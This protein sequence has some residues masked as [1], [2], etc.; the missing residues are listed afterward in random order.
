MGKTKMN[1]T[2]PAWHACGRVVDALAEADRNV[3]W[4]RKLALW[5][6]EIDEDL[7]ISTRARLQRVEHELTDLAQRW[8]ALGAT[9]TATTQ[10]LDRWIRT[11]ET[12][13]Y[14]PGDLM[15]LDGTVIRHDD[16]GGVLVRFGGATICLPGELIAEM[17]EGGQP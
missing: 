8:E 5:L 6:I 9:S 13:E 1:K 10:S 4:V 3:E 7:A 2:E 11:H 15:T 17:E 12:E 14:K 16:D